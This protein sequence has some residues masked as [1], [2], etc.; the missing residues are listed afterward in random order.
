MNGH[1][2]REN[3]VSATEYQKITSETEMIKKTHEQT[4]LAIYSLT[5]ASKF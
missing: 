4:E 5:L 3:P 2:L 1:I